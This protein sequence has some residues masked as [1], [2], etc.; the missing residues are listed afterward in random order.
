MLSCCPYCEKFLWVYPDAESVPEPLRDSQKGIYK[1]RLF[2]LFNYLR[3][4]KIQ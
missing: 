1:L 3:D 2:I 4:E